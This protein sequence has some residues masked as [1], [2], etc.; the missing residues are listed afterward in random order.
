[1]APA[2]V[3]LI[4]F[5]CDG[6]L[7]DSEPLSM[8]ILLQTIAEAGG[9]FT[10]AEGYDSFL[11]KSL[12]SVCDLLRR[13]H[14]IDMDEAA[15][16]RMRRRL[17]GAFRR[18]LRPIRAI[19]ETLSA[20]EHRFCV[21][22]S[23]QPERIGLALEVTGLAGFFDNHVFSAAMVE[24]GK[25]APDLFLHAARQMGV[26]PA[27]CIVVEDSAAGIEAARAAGM[28]AF[29]FTGGSHARSLEHR[30][31]LLALEPC[32]VFDDMLELPA[33]VRALE[34]DRAAG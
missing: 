19:A 4:I 9:H 13:D 8:R 29:G 33:L 32:Q 14:G 2:P 24:H 1:M 17:Y 27:D 10:P 6:V 7:V 11:G 15:L 26:E 20:L 18:E 34:V 5:D 28:G 31:R 16:E 12:A 22:S 30:R 23:S 21:A 25:P 3:E